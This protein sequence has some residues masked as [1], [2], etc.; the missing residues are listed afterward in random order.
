MPLNALFLVCYSDFVVSFLLSSPTL[1]VWVCI[2]FLFICVDSRFRF[3]RPVKL[4]F[5][6]EPPWVL[7]LKV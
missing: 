5:Y 6:V 3:Q 2:L 7:A 1:V 4:K